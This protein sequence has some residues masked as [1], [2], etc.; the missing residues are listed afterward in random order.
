MMALAAFMVI[1]VFCAPA[2]A[3]TK[4]KYDL[5]VKSEYLTAPGT[6]IAPN[7]SFRNVVTVRNQRTKKSPKAFVYAYVVNSSG[8]KFNA[9][10][11]PYANV[12]RIAGHR[13]KTVTMNVHIPGSLA[14][15]TWYYVTCVGAK[16]PNAV[17]ARAKND[18][19]EYTI[20][21]AKASI[22]SLGLKDPVFA[23]VSGTTALIAIATNGAS[24]IACTVDSV[25]HSC[26]YVAATLNGLAE[27]SH[28]FVAT[29]TDRGGNTA[30]KS[31]SFNTD[32]TPP[33]GGAISYPDGL[34]VLQPTLTLTPGTDVHGPVHW[35]VQRATAPLNINVCGGFTAFANIFTADVGTGVADTTLS[36]QQCGMY[37]LIATDALGNSATFTSPN[38]TQYSLP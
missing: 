17:D 31:F 5:A 1:A 10:G 26:T 14:Q 20:P 32:A 30:F 19:R 22:V 24:S 38:V 3:A 18:C 21:I 13:T 6:T 9:L 4:F 33:S 37:Q 23:G 12:P 25:A 2:S 15:G 29:V 8:S 28:T 11:Y 16:S 27:G 34:Q 7:Q 36:D 35:H